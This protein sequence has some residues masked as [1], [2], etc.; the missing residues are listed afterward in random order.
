MLGCDGSSVPP[1]PEQ[2]PIEPFEVPTEPPVAEPDESGRRYVARWNAW[3][4]TIDPESIGRVRTRDALDEF[5]E[6]REEVGRLGQWDVWTAT[7]LSKPGDEDWEATIELFELLQP[8]LDAIA[9]GLSADWFI[10]RIEASVPDDP[11]LTAESNG[12]IDL[13]LDSGGGARNGARQL[14]NRAQ[15]RMLLGDSDGFTRDLVAIIASYRHSRVPPTMVGMLAETGLEYLATDLLLRA[16]D[17]DP[18]LLSVEQ[19]DS[20]TTAIE[21]AGRPDIQQIAAMESAMGR[22]SLRHLFDGH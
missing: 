22:W 3:V 12:L 7:D 10:G 5:R 20:I 9:E 4:E 18:D 2:E 19:L 15:H 6:I 13:V 8:Q 21:R 16:L 17:S 14:A 1:A 11:Y